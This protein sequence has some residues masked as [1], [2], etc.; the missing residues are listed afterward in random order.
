MSG[1]QALL[2]RARKDLG[3]GEPNYLQKRYETLVGYSLGGNFPWCAAAISIWANESGN[4]NVIKP[5]AYTVYMAQ[6]FQK[7][8]VW[9]AGTDANVRDAKPGDIV[10]FDWGGTNSVGAI[11][12]VGVVERNLGDGRVICIEGNTSD[13]CMRR[14]RS[15]SVIAGYGRPKYPAAK[16]KPPP[17]PPLKTNLAVPDGTPQLHLGSTGKNVYDLQRCLNRVANSNL[18]TDG[19]YGRLTERAV[20][21]FKGKHGLDRDGKYGVHT[22]GKLRMAVKAS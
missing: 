7:A 16:P 5:R 8:G 21:L 18:E 6:D 10:L 20:S 14:V 11:D 9:Y 22:A 13:K 2:D 17:K 15:A 12:H 4:S 1:A 3:L 19:I